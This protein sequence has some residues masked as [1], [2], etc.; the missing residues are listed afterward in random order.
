MEHEAVWIR[1]KT[2]GKRLNIAE[3][4]RRIS[5]ARRRDLGEHPCENGLHELP[6]ENSV[7]GVCLPASDFKAVAASPFSKRLS[8]RV[9]SPS[10]S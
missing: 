1:T 3:F 5:Q 4:Q 8:C 2:V 10:C 9:E 7:R 6:S